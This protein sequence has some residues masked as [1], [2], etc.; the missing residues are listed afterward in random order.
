MLSLLGMVL[1]MRQAH[2]VANHVTQTEFC[3]LP[4]LSFSTGGELKLSTVTAK[5]SIPHLKGVSF[6]L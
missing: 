4:V 6:L 1:R 2:R 3:C 5:V